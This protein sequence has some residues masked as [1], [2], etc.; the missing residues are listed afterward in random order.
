MSDTRPVTRSETCIETDTATPHHGADRHAI[1]DDGELWVIHAVKLETRIHRKPSPAGYQATSDLS[2]D[3]RVVPAFCEHL[4]VT[5]G[6]LD[7]R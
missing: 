6:D 1:G 4:A 7:L 3:R 2:A 5:L